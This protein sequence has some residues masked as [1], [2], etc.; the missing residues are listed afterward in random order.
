MNKS[1]LIIKKTG[2]S[3]NDTDMS[4]EKKNANIRSGNDDLQ[5]ADQMVGADIYDNAELYSSVCLIDIPYHLDR[6]FD[7]KVPGEFRGIIR[8]GDFVRVP[9]GAGNRQHLALVISCTTDKPELDIKKLKE[10]TEILPSDMS[11][12]EEQTS[13]CEYMHEHI[14]CSYGDAV[15]AIAPSFFLGKAK[16]VYSITQYG[17]ESLDDMRSRKCL[18]DTDK[19]RMEILSEISSK[20]GKTL[21]L[22]K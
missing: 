21:F 16:T 10:I 2:E 12:S 6:L 3:G 5:Y 14:I 11:L 13:L 7:Y 1:Q 20:K 18:S 19:I 8:R 17:K 15:H 9:F 22:F 4:K